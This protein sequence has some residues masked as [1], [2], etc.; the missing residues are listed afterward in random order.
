[1]YALSHS[2][3]MERMCNNNNNGSNRSRNQPPT[4]HITVTWRQKKNCV[5]DNVFRM[6]RKNWIEIRWIF[7]IVRNWKIERTH[8]CVWK[9]RRKYIC[10][11]S[12]CHT[13]YIARAICMYVCLS[14]EYICMNWAL[15][16]IKNFGFDFFFGYIIGFIRIPPN[17]SQ[18]HQTTIG[19]CNKQ[20]Y[21]LYCIVLYACKENGIFF[22]VGVGDGSAVVVVC[23]CYCLMSVV[24]IAGYWF[25]AKDYEQCPIYECLDRMYP[26]YRTNYHRELSIC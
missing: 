12:F 5:P 22:S 8:M 16:A 26:K 20:T 21:V 9:Q 25:W 24:P 19:L 23:C 11:K 14:I 1:M 3:F 13:E 4:H 15:C 2:I 10:T 7:E 17:L 18:L 6:I